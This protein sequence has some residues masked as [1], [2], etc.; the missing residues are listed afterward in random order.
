M[1]ESRWLSP[2]LATHPRLVLGDR[3]FRFGVSDGELFSEYWKVTATAGRPELVIAGNRTGHFFHA[4]MHEREEY[5]HLKISL[6]SGVIERP[7]RPPD[8]IPPGVRRLVQLVLPIE[9]V[10]HSR[11]RRSQRVVWYPVPPNSGTWV[12]FT[13][14]HTPSPPAIANADLLDSVSLADGTA[15]VV[16]ARHAPAEPGSFTIPAEDPDEAR[17]LLRQPGI[18]MLVHGVHPDGC[19]WFLQLES[20]LRDTSTM[21]PTGDEQVYGRITPFLERVEAQLLAVPPAGQFMDVS[22]IQGEIMTWYARTRSLFSAVRVLLGAGY[23]EEAVIL[24]RSIFETSLQLEYLAAANETDRAAL[25]LGEVSRATAAFRQL[26]EQRRLERPD[27]EQ[28]A[29]VDR[30]LDE[31]VR[32]IQRAQRR[33]GVPRLRR[34]PG[35]HALAR[36]F[37][38]MGSYF[39]SRLAS[40]MTHG[41]HLAQASRRSGRDGELKVVHRSDDLR[42]TAGVGTLAAEAALHAQRATAEI[43]AWD[44]KDVEALIQECAELDGAFEDAANRDRQHPSRQ[45]T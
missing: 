8:V 9:A 32:M 14:L 20:A 31:R 15:V 2:W 36:R 5:W 27:A 12:E 37:G 7:W 11:P 45:A 13:I 41:G 10:R 35:D 40:E 21:S 18:A 33:F 4:T 6:P 22:P 38:H 25:V 34:F 44:A 43:M 26:D 42:Q 28:D 29:D 1:I 39:G 24:A 16:I 3:S 17:R 30:H 23:P 19:I